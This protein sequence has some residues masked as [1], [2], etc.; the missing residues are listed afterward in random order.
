M[1]KCH[2]HSIII[3]INGMLIRFRS[4]RNDHFYVNTGNQFLNKLQSRIAV[5]HD[6]GVLTAIEKTYLNYM[7]FGSA[8]IRCN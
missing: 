6:S 4:H 1:R 8:S 5:S 3:V 7:S 2:Q